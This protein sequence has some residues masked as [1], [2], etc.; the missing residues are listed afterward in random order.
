MGASVRFEP[1]VV[2]EEEF[3]NTQ[4][5]IEEVFDEAGRSCVRLLWA[6]LYMDQGQT[7]D[8]V[9][10]P[11]KDRRLWPAP[12]AFQEREEIVVAYIV[13]SPTG[14]AGNSNPKAGSLS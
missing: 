9:D 1:E 4:E 14:Y 5:P 10:T 3:R 12:E 6:T 2:R 8:I 7:Y 11:P 13:P